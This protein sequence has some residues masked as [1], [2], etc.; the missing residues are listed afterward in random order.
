MT[1]T[2][3]GPRIEPWMQDAACADKPVQWWFP[4]SVNGAEPKARAAIAL[5]GTCPVR[6]ACLQ[7]ALDGD[8][9]HGIFGGLLPYERY[10]ITHNKTLRKD[11][12]WLRP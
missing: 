8:D 4:R 5:C 11:S 6:V 2:Y 9:R 10:Q 7:F 12:R 1:A 3:D